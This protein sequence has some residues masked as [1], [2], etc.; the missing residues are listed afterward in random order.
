MMKKL[1]ALYNKIM[2]NPKSEKIEYNIS[3]NYVENLDAVFGIKEFIANFYDVNKE[4]FH[5]EYQNKNLLLEDDNTGIDIRYMIIGNSGSR[6][7]SD[8]IGEHGE[9]FKIGALTLVRLGYK[10][11]IETVGY[12]IAFGIE[13]SS[14]L[15]ANVMFAKYV[16]NDRKK[17]T[18]LFTECKKQS[19]EKAKK[20]F[21]HL[22]EHTP[23]T[24]SIIDIEG[25]QKNIYLNGLSHTS[26][27][28][29]FSYNIFEK[30]L[31][32]NRDRNFIAMNV[33]KEQISYIYQSLRNEK[34]ISLV[35]ERFLENA[36]NFDKYLEA[37]IFSDITL[38]DEQK[39]MYAK[40]IDSNTYFILK[41]SKVSVEGE[42]KKVVE[43]DGKLFHFLSYIG[44]KVI[45]DE[46]FSNKNKDI[47]SVFEFT[48]ET[49]PLSSEIECNVVN[50]LSQY[51]K[52]NGNTVLFSYENIKNNR[53]VK[54]IIPFQ[55]L[56][57]YIITFKPSTRSSSSSQYNIDFKHVINNLLLLSCCDFSVYMENNGIKYTFL[58]EVINNK[59]N[60][61]V[62][63]EPASHFLEKIVIHKNIPFEE[64]A[65]D[66]KETFLYLGCL[67]KES[68][69]SLYSYQLQGT[70]DSTYSEVKSIIS[71]F[72][73]KKPKIF[74]EKFLKH[75]SQ[76]EKLY[77]YNT[78]FTTTE[79]TKKVFKKM[80]DKEL[81]NH[82]LQSDDNI[83]NTV[84]KE[85]Y[86]YQILKTS[87]VLLHRMLD[88]NLN[89]Q[90]SHDIFL[91]KQNEDIHII[92]NSAE[93]NEAIQLFERTYH[94]TTTVYLTP[95]L[96]NNKESLHQDGNI[97]ISD[98][99][100]NIPIY[101]M[102]L[103]A[104]EYTNMELQLPKVSHD[105]QDHLTHNILK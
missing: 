100:S 17:G 66:E 82:V 1:I 12:T 85:K 44:A 18:I 56:D 86:G 73:N 52:A 9:G 4:N 32:S 105:M 13:E 72:A 34:I 64:Q 14:H 62:K 8:K 38:T 70:E 40:S 26:K 36:Y 87:S 92:P 24:E 35:M 27:R 10:V 60:I 37:S 68:I 101:L 75:L 90:T 58:K 97:Y 57:D 19:F 23:I 3:A 28:A 76:G 69:L 5:M 22:S 21:L 11:L 45:Y 46:R 59:I 41:G 48:E 31:V 29:C 39:E 55:Q 47:I 93:L 91:E 67:R 94:V 74:F 81:P 16:K 49:L 61:L 95:I 51:G 20:M 71:N 96:P 50:T 102:T 79:K 43:V 63:K 2:G 7:F 30:N 104:Y 99:V 15:N 84:A 103:I 25:T 65:M 54:K 78:E 77:E 6:E 83:Y 98:N 42:K 88:N 33:L 53:W 89:V 80:F